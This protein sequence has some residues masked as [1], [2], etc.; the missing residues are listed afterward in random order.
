V[1]S[2]H[3]YVVRAICSAGIRWRCRCDDRPAS[4]I[5]MRGEVEVRDGLRSGDR[6]ILYSPVDVAEGAKVQMARPRTP[7]S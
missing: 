6:V 2:V 3:A 1:Y 7:L 5:F 4:P